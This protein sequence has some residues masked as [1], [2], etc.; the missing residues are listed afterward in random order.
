MAT[1]QSAYPDALVYLYDYGD[2]SSEP[3]TC[4]DTPE[5]FLK[6]YWPPAST[7]VGSLWARYAPQY[8]RGPIEYWTSQTY[9]ATHRLDLMSDG[10][11]RVVKL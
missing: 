7:V 1:I 2:G 4:T 6:R 11:F 10:E 3:T 8:E 5:S 9:L